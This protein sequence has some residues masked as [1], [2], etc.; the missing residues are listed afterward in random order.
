MKPMELG[1]LITSKRAP[2]SDSGC[3]LATSSEQIADRHFNEGENM[4]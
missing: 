2:H 1:K 4:S 3:R